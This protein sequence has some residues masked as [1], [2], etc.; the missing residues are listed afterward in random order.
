MELNDHSLQSGKSVVPQTGILISIQ[1][2][3]QEKAE[4]LNLF[5][6]VMLTLYSLMTVFFLLSAIFLVITKG[7]KF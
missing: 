4:G 2:Y 5:E 1:E 7:F 6:K 3:F